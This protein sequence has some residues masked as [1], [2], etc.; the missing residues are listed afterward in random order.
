MPA[1]PTGAIPMEITADGE[2]NF[3]AGLATASVNVIVRYGGDILYADKVVFDSKTK[4]AMAEG[5][6]R[7]YTGPRLYRGDHISYNF[8]THAVTSTDF[9]LATFPVFGA[10]RKVSTPD[11]NHYQITDGYVTTEN[12]TNPGFRIKAH[13]IEIYPNDRVVLK[14]VV[15][16]VG[17]VPVMWMPFFYQDLQSNDTT[18]SFRG[19]TNSRFGVELL[20]TVNWRVSKDFQ[21]AFHEDYRSRRGEAGGV[22]FKFRPTK[23]GS[24]FF[25]A[26]SVNDDDSKE[27]P[28]SIPRSPIGRDRYLFALQEIFPVSDGLTGKI[29][30]NVWSDPYITEDFY[31]NQFAGERMPDNTVEFTQWTPNFEVS[32]LGRLQPNR[33]FDGTERAPEVRLDLKPVSLFG[34]RVQYQGEASVVNFQ[35]N[36]SNQTYYNAVRPK[37]YSAYRWDTYHQFSLPQQFFGWLNSTPHVGFRGTAWSNDNNGLYTDHVQDSAQRAVVDAGEELSFKLSQ[38]WNDANVPGL[39]VDGLRHVVEPYMNAEAILP[40]AGRDLVRGFDDRVANTWANPLGFPGW[41]SVDS[42]DRQV[43]LR[44]GVRNKIQ[45]KRDGKNW[46]LLDWDL[47]TDVNLTRH[48]DEE[49]ILRSDTLS[50]AYSDLTIRPFP[51]L[52]FDSRAAID[53]KGN[54]YDMYDQSISWQPDRSYQFTVGDRL[55]QNVTAV[56]IYGLPIQNSNNIYVKNFWRLN[57]HWQFQTFHA[58]DTTDSHLSEQNYTIYR[59]LSSWQIG[60]TLS[61]RNN[62]NSESEQS[63]YLSFT[64]KAFPNASIRVSE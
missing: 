35:Q 41:N 42:I 14:N 12:R 62:R 61:E 48:Y 25:R 4:T 9:A 52:H 22:D 46:D 60:L 56:D 33:F 2:T 26:Y 50:H 6:V 11:D 53:T 30:A 20:S 34:S 59:D 13:T 18:V 47:Y 58:F 19:G 38:T 21:V 31:R 57:E 55:L 16:Y 43:V 49:Q 36:F 45:T 39:A 17:D 10:G 40:T 37:N 32:V 28:T 63:V 29:N 24:G 64:L 51:W 23:D 44:E 1:V 15:F 3:I 8:E 54:S 7:I 27:N 5:N